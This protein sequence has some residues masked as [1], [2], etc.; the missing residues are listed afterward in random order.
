MGVR[1]MKID[2]GRWVGLSVAAACAALLVSG[3]DAWAQDAKKTPP[4][5]A[6]SFCKGL[7]EKVC[8]GKTADC[9]W[10]VPKKG[11]QK[12]YCRLKP[13]KKA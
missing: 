10:I 13:G 1:T 9:A 6:A 7:D 8:K 3:F 11:K 5:K 12:A 4:A 2:G